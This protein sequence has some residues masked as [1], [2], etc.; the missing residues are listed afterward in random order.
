MNATPKRKRILSGVQPSGKLHLGNYFGAVRQHIAL[1]AQRTNDAFN[2][3]R[4]LHAELVFPVR[5]RREREYAQP[6]IRCRLGRLLLASADRA[7]RKDR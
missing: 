6:V 7:A 1:Q 5:L 2:P 3:H 4:L